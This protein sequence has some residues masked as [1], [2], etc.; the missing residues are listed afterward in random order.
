MLHTLLMYSQLNCN[1][2]ALSANASLG[3]LGLFC[4]AL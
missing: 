2:V 4:T 3:C 1:K